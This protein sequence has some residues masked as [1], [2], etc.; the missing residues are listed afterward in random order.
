MQR[1]GQLF[2]ANIRQNDLAFRYE[3]TTIAL[4][5]GETGEK[6]ALQAVEKLRKL[7]AD[8]KL[9][10]EIVPFS[11]GVAEAV[12][13]PQFDPVDIVTEVI[14]RADKALD[15]AVAQGM[16]RIVSLAPSVAAAAVA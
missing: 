8:V 9:S 7:L 3:K 5:L 15:A 4:V 13:R 1:I 12:V 16:G 6:E 11:A 10:E 2:A 14:N